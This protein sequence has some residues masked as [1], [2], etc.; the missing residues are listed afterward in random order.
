MPRDGLEKTLA[1]RSGPRNPTALLGLQ[2]ARRHHTDLP[3]AGSVTS[4]SRIG[5]Q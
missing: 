4:L 1:F 3:G 2:L 5:G